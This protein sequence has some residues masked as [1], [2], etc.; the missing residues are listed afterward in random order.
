MEMDNRYDPRRFIR[1]IILG[2]REEAF[3]DEFMWHC[4]THYACNERCPQG[5]RIS[6]LM[7]AIRNIAIR[8]GNAP[9]R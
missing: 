5:V 7:N 9:P 1:K 6:E 2:M 3:T 4:S 8:E